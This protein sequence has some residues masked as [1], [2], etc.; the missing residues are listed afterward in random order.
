MLN[1][2]LTNFNFGAVT[3]HFST[4]VKT[5]GVT[6]LISTL[7]HVSHSFIDLRHHVL[8]LLSFGFVSLLLRLFLGGNAIRHAARRLGQ[9]DLRK[10]LIVFYTRLQRLGA[11]RL[12]FMLL[13]RLIVLI[14]LVDKGVRELNVRPYFQVRHCYI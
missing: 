11:E 8:F 7:I 13:T 1:D 2:I 6:F 3:S 4:C 5:P 9:R 12:R 14:I 10:P